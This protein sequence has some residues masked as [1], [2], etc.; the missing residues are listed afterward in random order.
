MEFYLQRKGQTPFLRKNPK[1]L[2]GNDK[3][4]KKIF[5]Y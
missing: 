5:G 4:S 2:R 3:V 1:A